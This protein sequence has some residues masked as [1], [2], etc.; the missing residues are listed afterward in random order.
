MAGAVELATAYI[1]LVP[2]MK[3]ASQKISE[4]L[5]PAAGTAGAEGG[6]SLGSALMGGL[7]KFALP[8]AGV[9]AAFSVGKLVKDSTEQF[10]SYAGAV[11]GF[12]R[13]AGGAVEQFSGLRGAMQLSGVDVNNATGAI[14][15][16]SKNLGKAG[17]DSTKTA[18]MTK[19]LGESFKDAHGNIKPMSELLPGLSDKFKSMPDG[20]AKTALATQLFGR[21]GA[22][23][24]PFLNQ[25]SAGI[26]ELTKQAGKMGLVLDDTSMRIF[27]DAKK[28][29]REYST[30]IQGLKIQLGQS[31]TPAL[32]AVHN[33]FRSAMIPIIQAGTQAFIKA[34][35]PIMHFA[36]G[37]QAM[38]DRVRAGMTGIITLFS[39]GKFTGGLRKAL[40]I[41]EDSAVVGV[42]LK[43]RDG[44]SGAFGKIHAVLAQVAP[45]ARSVFAGLSSTIGPLIPQI[46]GMAGAMSPVQTI[47]KALGPVLPQLLSVF[48]QLA[49]VIGG[50]LGTALHTLLPVF[51]QLQGVFVRLFT[52]V[53][54]TVLPVVVRLVTMLGQTLTQ[55]V[56][57]V[58]PIITRIAQ[59]AATLIAQLAPILMHLISAVMPM[60]IT[61]FGALAAAI[62]PVIQILAAVLIPIIQAL[63]P[64]VVTV[65][66]VIANVITSVMQIIMGIIQ[67]VTGIIT[68]NWSM[69]WEGIKNVFSGIWNT[70]VA[71]VTGVFAIIWS[72]ISGGLSVLAGFIGGVLGNIGKFFSD[73][74]NNVVN[75][76]SGMIGNV[77]KFFSGLWGTVTGAL[78][79]AGQWLW[80]AGV[81]VVQGLLDGIKSLA[82]T[83]GNF[84]LSLLPGWIVAPFKAA[85][86]I[87]SPSRLF[88]AFGGFIG[89]GLVIGLEGSSSSIRATSSKMAKEVINAFDHHAITRGME[90]RLLAS[91]SSANN[92]LERLA[93]SRASVLGRLKN[94]TTAYVDALKIK[95]DYAASITASDMG[96]V[97]ASK[98][99]NLVG[100][101]SDQIYKT[102]E[103]TS[104]LAQLKKMGLDATTYKQLADGGLDSIPAAEELLSTGKS[105][106]SRVVALQ[107]QLGTA[108]KGLGA[109]AADNLYGAG[110]QSAA[111]LVNGLKSQAAAI[112]HQVTVIA[113]SMS[114]AIKKALGIRSPSTVFHGFGENIVEG[115]M[116]GVSKR[117]PEVPVLMENLVK[118]PAVPQAAI[119]GAGVARYGGQGAGVT[120]KTTINQV[121]NP[122]A[123]AHAVQ[124]RLTSLTV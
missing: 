36:E 64:V 101:L 46:M 67:V 80:D 69:V 111:G 19:L 102:K 21:A 77:G 56:P 114:A 32:D 52:Q 10:E 122:I 113:Q 72:V 88:K 124:R 90:N 89:E 38:A 6:S 85:L 60:V 74:W 51:V 98:T 116:R 115:L 53:L 59:L 54:A 37:V 110:V 49:T 123:T 7:K 17:Q 35:E 18:A 82:G 106:I 70:I 95:N 5:T 108:A 27:G 83:V 31:L 48:K 81:N 103:L 45:V 25:G 61:I 57:V 11:K 43:I 4:Q 50:T 33:V 112:S 40:G 92:T 14:T 99:L 28:S 20:A 100:D 9:V 119:G 120:Y 16:F 34:R 104:T 8:I 44:V 30:S 3:G 62:G 79:G 66:G 73:T 12:G 68:G 58:V 42:I 78:A 29:A 13:L 65:F 96:G 91:I 118:V 109:T 41:E 97:D 86:G 121:D 76:V 63:M 55:L 39:T 22:Q 93:N 26:A 1:A 23:M 71:V 84:F 87:Q 75:G 15:I 24:L 107:K 2:S 117:A 105:G 47:F 94:A